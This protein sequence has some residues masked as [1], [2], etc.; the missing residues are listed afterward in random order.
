[1][2]YLIEFLLFFAKSL[3]VIVAIVIPTMVI[4]A[5]AARQRLHQKEHLEVNHINRRYETMSNTIDAVHMPKKAFKEKIKQQKKD[6]KASSNGKKHETTE[7]K[8]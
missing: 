8:N 3:I 7:D 4:S 6:R 5:L 2:E 1:M